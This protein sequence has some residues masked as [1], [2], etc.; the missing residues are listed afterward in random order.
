[1]GDLIGVFGGTFDPPHLGHCILAQE[2][3]YHLGLEQTYWIPAGQPPHKP[4]RP[5]SPIEDRVRM[6]D[7]ITAVDPAFEL[8]RVDADR[9]GPQYSKDTLLILQDEL[10]DAKLVYLMGADSLRDLSQ[11]KDPDVF[12]SRA[13]AIGVM[14]RP[15]IDLEMERI[16]KEI[17][18]LQGKIQFFPA[19]L[20]EISGHT[21]R[22]RIHDGLPCRYM[23]PL[24][25]Y[26]YICQRKLYR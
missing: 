13:H 17:P 7:L 4:E 14:L 25:V 21:I 22:Q 2:A 16:L 8:S 19:P 20:V 1:M 24:A 26:D 15:G 11:W 6:V 23:L 12:V 3:G 5:I 9:E 10:P 18:S